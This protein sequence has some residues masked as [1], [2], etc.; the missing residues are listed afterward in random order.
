MEWWWNQILEQFWKFWKLFD[1][2]FSIKI[3]K[4]FILIRKVHKTTS[5]SAPLLLPSQTHKK[6]YSSLFIQHIHDHFTSLLNS[7][8]FPF[9]RKYSPPHT[10]NCPLS[11]IIPR[12]TSQPAGLCLSQCVRFSLIFFKP[13]CYLRILANFFFKLVRGFHFC[14]W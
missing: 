1:E 12:V 7:S 3:V 6:K 11:D 4:K 9:I 14:G 2:I 5:T 8:T 10:C 13:L